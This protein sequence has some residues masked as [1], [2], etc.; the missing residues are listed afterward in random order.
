MTEWQSGIII[1][2]FFIIIVLSSPLW[3]KSFSIFKAPPILI[4]QL[5]K[6][7]KNCQT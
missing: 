6:T 2:V 5:I 7:M 3:R 4:N 1:T